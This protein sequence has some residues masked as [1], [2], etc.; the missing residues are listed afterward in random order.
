MY[1][2]NIAAKRQ[3]HPIVHG[4]ETKARGGVVLCHFGVQAHHFETTASE[5]EICLIRL[6]GVYV[7]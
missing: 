4:G 3:E 7:A 5:S 6:P 2:F 1:S